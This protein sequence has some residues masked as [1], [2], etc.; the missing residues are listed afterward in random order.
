[1]YDERD[2]II[3]DSTELRHGGVVVAVV[4]EVPVRRAI[5][6]NSF[7]WEDGLAAEGGGVGGILNDLAGFDEVD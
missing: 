6:P 7:D 2:E 5:R 1:M 3:L 4:N